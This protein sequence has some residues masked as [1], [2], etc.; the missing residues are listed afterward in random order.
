M[1]KKNDIILIAVLLIIGVISLAFINFTRQAGGQVL[2][3]VNGEVYKTLELNQDT[4]I[5]IDT[6][7]GYH[8]VVT[9]K[10]GEVSMSEA[11][12]PD[13]ICVKHK[14]I[15]YDNESI[16]CLPHKVVVTITGGADNGVDIIAQ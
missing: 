2:I 1:F 15:K 3:T 10:D 13:K 9:I 6:D 5:S 4:T 8:N 16:I 11:N 7:E 14:S 12:C